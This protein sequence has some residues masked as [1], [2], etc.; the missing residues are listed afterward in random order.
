MRTA[1]KKTIIT[2]IAIIASVAVIQP[3]TAKERKRKASVKPVKE[4]SVGLTD[5]QVMDKLKSTFRNLQVESVSKTPVEG[6]Y[7]FVANGGSVIAYYAPKN[8]MLFF[9]NLFTKDMK[10][11][12]QERRD[13]I[14]QAKLKE[15]SLDTAIKIGSGKHQVIEFTDPD[16]PYCRKAADYF[17]GKDVTK[18]VFMRP[19]A[20][21]HPKAAE[22]SLFILSS[23]DPEK[24]Y[25]DVMAGKHDKEDLSKAG[26]PAA[27][28]RLASHGRIADKIGIQGTPTF[29][30][31]GKM[32]AGANIQMF[33]ALLSK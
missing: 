15:I 22:K 30:I 21:L 17:K 2:I 19:I 16:C 7:E 23:D 33:D 20:Q 18:Y 24:A 10:S 8:D 12:T 29:W 25:Y 5:Q 26:S 28:E 6:I 13:A 14:Q 11:L 9:G 31:D 27:S 4:I 32:V 1:A 3:A